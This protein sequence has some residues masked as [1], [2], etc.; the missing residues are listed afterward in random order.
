MKL[1]TLLLAFHMLLGSLLPHA[2]YAELTK[3]PVLYEHYQTHLHRSQGHLSLA[4]FLL[5]HYADRQ[6]QQS[7]N[8]D[9]L[10]F[11]HHHSCV[12]IVFYFLT[13][14]HFEFKPLSFATVVSYCHHAFFFSSFSSG[15]F[16]PPK[17]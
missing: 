2:D 9:Q 3:L 14:F 8:H 7:E 16:Q 6:H 15:I 1:A 4:D 11:Q 13:N 5:M 17:L 12:G 10:P